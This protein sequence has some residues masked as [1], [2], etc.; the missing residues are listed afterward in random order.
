MTSKYSTEEISAANI[1]RAI[2]ENSHMQ[3]LGELKELKEFG[4]LEKQEQHMLTAMEE[5]RK[6]MFTEMEEQHKHMLTE[7]EE[8]QKTYNSEIVGFEKNEPH[9][10]LPARV[11]LA[12]E[13]Y[14]LTPP[15][16]PIVHNVPAVR[17]APSPHV[18]PHILSESHNAHLINAA[19][20]QPKVTNLQSTSGE[21]VAQE[22]PSSQGPQGSQGSHSLRYLILVIL[23]V[24]VLLLIFIRFYATPL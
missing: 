1:N 11:P 15:D 8:H 14:H 12:N 21:T 20:A 7:M 5:Q 17:A 9:I 3:T 22:Q 16:Q 13:P 18:V 2:Q 23:F 10:S 4:E 24:I 6:H 19:N